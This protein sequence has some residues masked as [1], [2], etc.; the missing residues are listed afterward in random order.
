MG[1]AYN[2]ARTADEGFARRISYLIAPDGTFQAIYTKVDVAEHPAQV[3]ADLE[4]SG[5]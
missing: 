3:L 1:L 4:A 2:A 5:G